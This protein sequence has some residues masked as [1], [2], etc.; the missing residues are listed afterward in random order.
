M[1]EA[2]MEPYLTM[3]AEVINQ[4]ARDIATADRQ[5][6]RGGIRAGDRHKN[7]LRFK[8]EAISWL[9]SK[10]GIEVD[11]SYIAI[12]DH[13]GRDPGK[14]RPGLL[15]GN[16][17]GHR[18]SGARGTHKQTASGVPPR[19]TRRRFD[20]PS[21]MHRTYRI[22]VAKRKTNICE[23]CGETIELGQ[24]YG[25]RG[26]SNGWNTAHIKCALGDALRKIVIKPRSTGRKAA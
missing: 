19:K 24:E 23:Y 5:T 20:C 2:A 8:S 16:P 25:H 11:N 17:I 26:G 9:K 14:D 13:I 18:L 4:A 15:A 12:C 1:I 6:L 3:W 22:S 10:N 21:Q 7:A